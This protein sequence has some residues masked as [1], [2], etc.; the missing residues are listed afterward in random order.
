MT[1]GLEVAEHYIM[2]R[3][4]EQAERSWQTGDSMASTTHAK[5][6]PLY[7]ATDMHSRPLAGWAREK[8]PFHMAIAAQATE[9][10]RSWSHART[11]EF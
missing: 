10:R 3:E 7:A 8:R 1:Q 6:L 5:Y 4:S 9:I 11:E 2:P